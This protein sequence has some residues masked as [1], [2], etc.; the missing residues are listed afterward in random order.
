M[1]YGRV[2]PLQVSKFTHIRGRYQF[3]SCFFP[4]SLTASSSAAAT[5]GGRSVAKP[6]REQ[7][8]GARS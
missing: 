7:S 6:P 3:L 5:E 4:K 8:A 2:S 1:R